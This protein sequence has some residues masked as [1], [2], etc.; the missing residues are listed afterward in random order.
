MNLRGWAWGLTAIVL[1]LAAGVIGAVVIGVAGTWITR[2][3]P[4]T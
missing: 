4:E 2:D 1:V 3:R